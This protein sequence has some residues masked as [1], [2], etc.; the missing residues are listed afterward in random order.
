[1]P[2]IDFMNGYGCT[3]EIFI[4]AFVCIYFYCTC[5]YNSICV[6]QYIC[7]YSLHVIYEQSNEV[8]KYVDYLLQLQSVFCFKQ[9]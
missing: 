7:A 8:L 5:V 1:M 4:Y 2:W 9:N 6:I 3:T